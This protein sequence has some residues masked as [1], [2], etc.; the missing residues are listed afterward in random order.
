MNKFSTLE[1]GITQY[2]LQTIAWT[3][4]QI[5]RVNIKYLILKKV[6]SQTNKNKTFQELSN[7]GIVGNGQVYFLAYDQ[8]KRI[9]YDAKKRELKNKRND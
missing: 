9:Y 2:W 3:S 7:N 5:D 8:I 6:D 1:S 4:A